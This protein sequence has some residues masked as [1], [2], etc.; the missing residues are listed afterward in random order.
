MKGL[1]VAVNDVVAC[2]L[3]LLD[4]VLRHLIKRFIHRL[5]DDTEI[6]AV[7]GRLTW[8]TLRGWQPLRLGLKLERDTRKGR[9]PKWHKMFAWIVFPPALILWCQYIVSAE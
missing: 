9:G 5:R 8:L 4:E 2:D 6:G 3:E 7:Y 1:E